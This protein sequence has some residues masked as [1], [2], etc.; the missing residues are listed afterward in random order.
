[1]M[2]DILTGGRDSLLQGKWFT[3]IGSNYLQC[4]ILGACNVTGDSS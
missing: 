2:R 1:M 4:L 3:I